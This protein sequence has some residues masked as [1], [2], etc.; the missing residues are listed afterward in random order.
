ML[1][2]WVILSSLLLRSTG[3]FQV[4]ATTGNPPTTACKAVPGTPGWPAPDVW[5]RLNASTGGRLLHVPPPG[6]VCHPD[7]PTYNPTQCL[8]VQGNSTVTG[9]WSYFS[10]HDSNPISNAMNE[11]NNDSCL[12]W[13]KYTCS[14]EGYPVYVINATTASHVKLGVDFGELI[15]IGSS[16]CL[17]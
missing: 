15:D 17:Y 13:A 12:P 2:F 6:A 14:G 7:Q 10:F 9:L 8:A 3:P 1:S 16:V 11:F 4:Q 5:D